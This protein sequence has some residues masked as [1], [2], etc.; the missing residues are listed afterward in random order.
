[1]AA[2]LLHVVLYL[3]Q[4]IPTLPNQGGTITGTLT[5]DTKTPAAGVRVAAMV[6]PENFADVASAASL[7]S[8]AETDE[9]GRYRLENVPPG[10]YYLTAGRVE[11]PTYYPGTLDI[12]AGRI[13][14]VG[15]GLTVAGV[16]FALKDISD[17]GVETVNAV[18]RIPIEIQIDDGS[19]IPI[20]SPRGKVALGLTLNSDGSK[21]DVPLD[22]S[23]VTLPYATGDYMV[24]VDNLPDGY[25]VKSISFG[26][27]DLLS[28]PLHLT[29]E[30][31]PV[32]VPGERMAFIATQ[33]GVFIQR[34]L[35]GSLSATTQYLIP[36]S[37]APAVISGSITSSTVLK[38]S[39]AAKPLP[40]SV[41]SGVRVRGKTENPAQQEIYISGMP[42]TVYSDGSFEFRGVPPG[43]H[44]VAMF[45]N[46]SSARQRG[47]V[48]RV[49]D[50]DIDDLELQDVIVL[51]ENILSA[52][53]IPPGKSADTAGA[54]L[55]AIR[56][57]IVDSATQ[58]P[59]AGIV[60]IRGYVRSLTN[61]LPADGEFEIE[62]LLPGTYTLKIETFERTT[63]TRAVVIENGDVDLKLSVP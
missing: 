15:A 49:G 17:R 5:T 53:V 20:F 1:M 32:P 40:D 61:S 29:L 28:K 50:R 48:I 36:V 26:V 8:I 18:V 52:S 33:S 63:L 60:T 51:P 46:P 6:Q 57:H 7:A 34:R 23:S 44:F 37:A 10:R 47:A 9:A 24:R 43:R 13:V 30:N 35:S 42:G 39:L 11:L 59:V 16:D 62:D 19:R 56:L 3:L 54:E 22:L 12:A 27:V 55:H 38:V 14:T 31:L 4:G 58:R 21:S 45:S 41:S 2:I 25:S